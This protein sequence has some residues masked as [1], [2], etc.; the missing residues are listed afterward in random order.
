M[1]EQKLLEI[2]SKIKDDIQN[3]CE[4]FIKVWESG[5]LAVFKEM[6]FCLMTPQSKAEVC[7][8]TAEEIF[9]DNSVFVAP[10]EQLSEKLKKVRFRNNKAS[11]IVELRKRFVVNGKPEIRKFLLS[12]G[13]NNVEI[14]DWLAKNIKGYGLKEASHFLRNV[15]MGKELAILDRHILRNLVEVGVLEQMP[16]S[17]NAVKYHE[18]ERAMKKFSDTIGIPMSHLDFVIW[19]NQTGRIFK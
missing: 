15:G 1:N 17:L 3:K 7:W 14:R 12:K 9:S 18:I 5:E 16:K 4:A 6:V 19:Y 2:Y 8:Q 11:Y 10:V 13:R